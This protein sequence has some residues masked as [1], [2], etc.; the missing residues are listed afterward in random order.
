VSEIP[1]SAA[2]TG[3]ELWT[4]ADTLEKTLTESSA[5]TGDCLTAMTAVLAKLVALSSKEEDSYER[6][7]E[8]SAKGLR[9]LG[10]PWRES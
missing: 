7:L 10:T 6:M 8:L 2:Q 9:E 1:R 3:T 5:S 4:L